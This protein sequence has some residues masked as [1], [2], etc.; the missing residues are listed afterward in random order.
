MYIAFDW[1]FNLRANQSE[2]PLLSYVLTKIFFSNGLLG[3]NGP[4]AS[5]STPFYSAQANYNIN[6]SLFGFIRLKY[7][8][9]I[10]ITWPQ[11]LSCK[12]FTSDPLR[13]KKQSH[14]NPAEKLT[15]DREFDDKVFEVSSMCSTLPPYTR[16]KSRPICA[17]RRGKVILKLWGR[18]L[19]L[20]LQLSLCTEVFIA[21]NSVHKPSIN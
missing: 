3:G 7:F 20:S 12:L 2:R 13:L 19:T 4:S 14:L 21:H 8:S 1:P 10:K 15:P 5:R 18:F 11:V 16:C 17:D 9:V 6:R